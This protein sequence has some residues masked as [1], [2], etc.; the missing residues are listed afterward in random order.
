M[1]P[2]RKLGATHSIGLDS[3]WKSGHRERASLS[4][5]LGAKDFERSGAEAPFDLLRSELIERG[6]ILTRPWGPVSG[7]IDPIDRRSISTARG[8]HRPFC[9]RRTTAHNQ[10][11][12]FDAAHSRCCSLRS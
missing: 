10:S 12:G 11:I 8:C 9:E 1:G 4:V 2:N 5:R 6:L 3:L 7:S